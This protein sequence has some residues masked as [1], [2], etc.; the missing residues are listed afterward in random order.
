M[1]T[2]HTS[3]KRI[4]GGRLA[5]PLAEIRGIE[6]VAQLLDFL[7]RRYVEPG[8][9]TNLAELQAGDDVV[10]VAEVKSITRR[11]MRSR[12]GHLATVIVTDGS[13]E[14]SLTFFQSKA[15]AGL[16][17]GSRGLFAGKV[18]T[19]KGQLQLT[20]PTF[21]VLQAAADVEFLAGA[22]IAGDSLVAEHLSHL[23][24]V[25]TPTGTIS[26]WQHGDA[27]K[28]ILSSI[29][30]LVDPV[31]IEVVTAHGM[32]TRDDTM[33]L[34]HR[35]E[36]RREA[37]RAKRRLKY[38]EALG[39]QLVL[40]QRRWARAA[41]AGTS[42]VRRTGGIADEFDVRLPFALTA[43]QRAVGAEIEAE[44]AAD[45]PM[46]R[47]L[48]GEVGSGKT[49]VAL[50]AMLTVVDSGGQAALLA[51]TEVLAVQHHRSMVAMLGD[52]AA[53]GLLGGAAMG[54]QVVLLTGSQNAAERRRALNAAVTGEAGIVVGTHALIQEG[55]DFADLGLVVVDEQHRFGVHQRD[56]LRGKA[57]TAPH[58]LVMTATPIPRTVAMTVFGD[59][60]TST[61]RELPAGRSPIATHVVETVNERWVDRTWARVAEEVR[62]GHRA[63]VVCP[64]IGETTGRGDLDD[65]VVQPAA[66]G[67]EPKDRSARP[68]A[69]V[70]ETLDELRANPHLADI[71]IEALHGR[72][73]SD[74][75]D[76]VMADFASGR[77]GVLVATTVIEVGVDVPDASVMVIRDAD[78]FGVSQLHQ[79]RGRVGRG[80]VAG[81]CLLMT[82]N[83][84][85]KA[86]ERLT[87]VAATTDGFELARLDVSQ[88]R[89]G[90]VLGARQSGGRNQLRLLSV[91]RDE[92]LI[93]LARADATTLVTDDP[94][95]ARWPLLAT[96]VDARLDEVQAAYLERG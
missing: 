5:N 50:R 91:L 37:S 41:E 60:E 6:T 21:R 73:E 42:R 61:L 24:P 4:I 87:A 16:D 77:I 88:R 19:Y 1:Y 47:L 75:K 36:T 72:M 22:G 66:E 44:L 83:P 9:L 3:V 51:P 89:E 40:A 31:P 94:T 90:D 17:I 93:D 82:D 28:L 49:I 95:L 48:Q 69:S 20:H 56:A 64:R 79:L 76:R 23:I 32:P 86:M 30:P 29:E 14:L 25:Y 39:L 71:R 55:V 62:A 63:Y 65:G 96:W 34:V 53:G 68:L 67:E 8:T 46:H 92:D 12:R 15:V 43:G 26:S 33:R 84:G 38:D 59:M 57:H 11:P 52:L 80:N 35:P 85:P 81:L 18:D 70:I 74:A 10:V 45:I 54:T 2:E 78:R 13:G 58:V 7:P 27:V